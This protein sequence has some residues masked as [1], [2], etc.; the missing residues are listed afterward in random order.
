MLARG[1][2]HLPVLTANRRLLG[3]LDDVD[4]MANER[5]APFHLQTRIAR[6]ATVAEVA[7]AAGELPGM[8]INLFDAEYQEAAGYPA[9]GLA[10]RGG[11][12]LRV[13][14]ARP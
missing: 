2:R 11:L 14:G 8:V 12:R 3:V 10:V 5:R 13:G 4:L 6:G 9:L 1:I 7:G